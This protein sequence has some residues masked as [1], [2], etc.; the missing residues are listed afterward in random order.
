VDDY[1]SINWWV[2]NVHQFND[3]LSEL[4]PKGRSWNIE[5]DTWGAEDGHRFDVIRE[6]QRMAELL[7]RLDVR[8]LSLSFV[9][10]VIDMARRNDL[11]IVTEGRHV[12]RPSV[13]ELISAVR[14]SPSFA[15]VKDPEAFLRDLSEGD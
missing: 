5:I 10:R 15:F 12:L 7:G 1:E 2:H 14:R 11:V 8:N 3:E 9:N 13:K 4:L 6:N